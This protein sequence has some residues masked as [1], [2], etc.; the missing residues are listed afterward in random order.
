MTQKGDHFAQKNDHLH[1]AV[2]DRELKTNVYAKVLNCW[3]FAI[4]IILNVSF[5][6]IVI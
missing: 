4:L 6:R 5:Y 2:P 1:P 3:P